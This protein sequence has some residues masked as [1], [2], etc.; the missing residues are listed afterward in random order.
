MIS[1]W[2]PRRAGAVLWLGFGLKRR[3]G[4]VLTE[5][6]DRALLYKQF[7]N[8]FARPYLQDAHVDPA[9]DV[10][11][12]AVPAKLQQSPLVLQAASQ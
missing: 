8:D 2:P 1:P 7:A 6:Q 10:P 5:Q 9:Q 4:K 12:V 3:S 11:P